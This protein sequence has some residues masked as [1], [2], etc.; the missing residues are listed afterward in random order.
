MGVLSLVLGA[1]LLAIFCFCFL[2]ASTNYRHFGDWEN[3]AKELALAGGA[4]V[5]AGT[6]WGKLGRLG[7]VLFGLTIISFGID[8]FIYAREAADYIPAWIPNHLFWMYPTGAALLGSGIA[9]VAAIRVRWFAM[10][11]GIM[12]FIWVVILHIPKA[13]A[14]GFSDRGGEVTSLF[15]ALAYCGTAFL[16]AGK[17]HTQ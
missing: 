8:H 9:I 4:F 7:A 13:V 16:I 1:V 6:A 2:P 15:L 17:R 10:L 12:I 3:A 14:A 11:L 5:C